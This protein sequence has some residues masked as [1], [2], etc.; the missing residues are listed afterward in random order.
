MTYYFLGKGLIDTLDKSKFY[1]NKFSNDLDLNQ[2][3]ALKVPSVRAIF[4]EKLIKNKA[5]IFKIIRKPVFKPFEVYHPRVQY[6]PYFQGEGQI[7]Y[8]LI[9]KKRKGVHHYHQNNRKKSNAPILRPMT[10]TNRDDLFISQSEEVEPLRNLEALF[11]SEPIN[12]L[13]SP[14]LDNY[15]SKAEKVLKSYLKVEEY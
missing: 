13:D 2:E 3:N 1:T 7:D 6:N 5:P 8:P 9:T 11:G 12:K 15:E 14:I 10:S 4:I